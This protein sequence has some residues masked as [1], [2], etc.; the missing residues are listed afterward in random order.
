M[1]DERAME[2]IDVPC[3]YIQKCICWNVKCEHRP[4]TGI[5]RAVS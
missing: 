3:L 1:S 4:V 5:F 2:V